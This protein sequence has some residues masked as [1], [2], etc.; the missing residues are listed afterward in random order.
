MDDPSVKPIVWLH[1]EIHTPPFTAAARIEAGE[2]LRRLQNGERLSMPHS[3]PMPSIGGGCHELRVNDEDAQWRLVYRIEPAAIVI[4]EIFAKRTRKTPRT[5][6]ETC[7]RRL[8]DYLES[9][10]GD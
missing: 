5:V 7:K 9:I 2:H 10:D 6:I 8:K 4:L 1:G 3:R